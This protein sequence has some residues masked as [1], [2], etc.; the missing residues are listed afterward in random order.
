MDINENFEYTAWPYW[1][2]DSKELWFQQL[3]RDQNHLVLYKADP[4]SGD[5]SLVY[6]E[7]QNTWVNWF[8]DLY[9]FKDGS[10]FLLRSDRSGWR[11]LYHYDMG[12]KLLRQLTDG[13]WEV[14]NMVYVDEE[15]ETIYCHGRNKP[16]TDM[17]L[18]SVTY[19]GEVSQRTSLPGTHRAN[20]A[21]GGEYFI[22]TYSNLEQAPK[23]V[24]M[25]RKGQLVRELGN[26][27]TA[28]LGDYPL[29]KAEL[30]TIPFWGWL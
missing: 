19:E 18:F 1:T 26:A 10:G 28:A 17:Q 30:F 3:N 9:F 11:H 12:G 27:A 14:S 16:T 23:M 8:K 29:G 24:L 15:N 4:I 2:P 25:N 7:K 5:K 20:I 21:P 6:Q 22:D 13:D